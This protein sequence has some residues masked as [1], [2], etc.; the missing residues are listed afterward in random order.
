MGHMAFIMVRK[1]FGDRRA[2]IRS[3]LY[4]E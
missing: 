3:L 2:R 1:G 4:L